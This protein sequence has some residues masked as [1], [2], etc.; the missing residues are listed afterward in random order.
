[1]DHAL[2]AILRPA[3]RA[4]PAKTGMN[5]LFESPLTIAIGAGA[6][7]FF[8]GVAWVQTGKNG[9]LYGIGGVV[10]VAVLLLIVERRTETDAEK[11]T[12][13]IHEIARQIEANDADGVV[14]HVV[15][16]KPELAAQGKRE[17]AKHKFSNIQINIHSVESQPQKQ[18]PQVVADF[19]AMISGSFAGGEVDLQG[20]PVYF[21]VT[22]WKDHDGEWKVA[23]YRYDINRP[24][25][26]ANRD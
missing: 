11:V 6:V 20:R 14:R 19:N 18:P 25:P 17:M 10:V 21:K 24:F 5:W 16:S 13:L 3:L 4:R 22:F 26:R 9:F 2:A 8:L 23:D 12:A 7:G 15:S 1:V